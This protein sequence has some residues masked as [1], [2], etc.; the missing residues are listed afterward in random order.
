MSFTLSV[1]YTDAVKCG[2]RNHVRYTSNLARHIFAYTPNQYLTYIIY[3]RMEAIAAT[4]ISSI[5]VSISR[6]F[7]HWGHNFNNVNGVYSWTF[8]V[9]NIVR[10]SVQ[11][12]LMLTSTRQSA[13]CSLTWATRW[14]PYWG[15]DALL[16]DKL[17]LIKLKHSPRQFR[18]LLC[19]CT[20]PCRTR[21]PRSS[22]QCHLDCCAGC[23]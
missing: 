22:L 1:G 7:C 6:P 13:L 10:G 2:L 19:K 12:L 3:I 11:V 21:G 14:L 8:A 20:M 4:L 23:S 15:R 16:L 5:S 18:V 9:E 17:Q